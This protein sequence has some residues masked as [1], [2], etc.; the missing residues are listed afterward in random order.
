MTMKRNYSR[1]KCIADKICRIE[2]MLNQGKFNLDITLRYSLAHHVLC[3]NL[4]QLIIVYTLG[5]D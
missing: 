4:M 1:E 5:L 3:N 2:I